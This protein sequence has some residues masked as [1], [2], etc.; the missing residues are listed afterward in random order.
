M[1]KFIHN[2]TPWHKVNEVWSFLSYLHVLPQTSNI[3]QCSLDYSNT[4]ELLLVKKRSKD[5]AK[6]V[7]NHRVSS[8]CKSTSEM[9]NPD[10]EKA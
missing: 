9:K 4:A 6:C 7:D 8:R 3:D 5:V 2:T 10:W 1:N